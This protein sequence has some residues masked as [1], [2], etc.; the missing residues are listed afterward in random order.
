[1]SLSIGTRLGTVEVLGIIGRGGM[2]EVYRAR[3]TKL[4]RDVA[5]KTL[6]DEFSHDADRL[7]RFQREAEVL[8]SLNH[9]NIAAIY[10]LQ[11]AEGSR[12]L[13]LE[14]VEGETLANRIAG[15]PIPIDE[16]LPVAKSICEALEA[17]H[18]QGVVHR[19]LKPANVKI[20]P[21]GKVKV[22]D[23]GLA[24]AMEST[25][26]TLLSNSP[27]LISVA[28]SNAGVILGTAGY[29][30]PEQAKGQTVDRRTDIW[31]FGVVLYEMLTG[32][33]LFSGETVSETMAFVMTKE[34]DWKALPTETPW[35]L[36]KLLRRCLI[37]DPRSRLRDIGEARIA[38]AEV[39]SGSEPNAPAPQSVS[40]PSARAWMSVS[41]VLTLIAAGLALPAVRYFRESALP[42]PSEMRLEITTP[43]TSAPLEFA[44]SPDGRYTVFVASGDGPQRLWLRPL[45]KTQALPMTGTEGATSPFWSPNSRS[46]GFTAL[47]KLKRID[48]AGGPPQILAD[49]GGGRGGTWNSDG[50]ILFTPSAAAPLFRVF[51]SGGAP[52]AITKLDPVVSHRF[53]SFL[54]GG[55]QFLFY[56]QGPPDVAGIYLGSLDSNTVRRLTPADT[57]GAYASPGWLLWVRD[58]SLV[59]QHLDLKRNELT[60]DPVTLADTVAF[61][62]NASAG[63]LSVSAS[64]LLAYRRGETGRHQLTWF[65]RAGKSLG[66]FGTPDDST[67]S[68]LALSPDGR[69]VAVNRTVQ[70][71][72]DVW[73]LNGTRASRF[74][75]DAAVEEFA[76]WSPDG[77]RIA[78]DSIRKGVRDLYIKPSSGAE[79]EKLL[80]QTSQDKYVTDW[81]PD[82]RFLLYQSLDPQTS[83]DLWVLPL[84]GDQKP[85][86]FL[87]TRFA[88]VVG[89][90]SPDGRWVAYF[91]NESGQMEVYVRPFVTP[92]ANPAGNL[93]RG[94]WQVS[95][96]GG[97]YP[98]WRPDGKELYYTGLDGR[99]M[100]VPISATSTTLE[101]G[102]P[103]ELFKPRIYGRGNLFAGLGRQYDVTRD[104]RFLVNTV[105]DDIETA[106]ITLLQN[107]KPPNP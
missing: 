3:D 44:L 57:Y 66:T 61:D 32:R 51:A 62:A 96:A 89:L 30:S 56:A 78:F 72:T 9:P 79:D 101:P 104:G 68:F 2:G 92:G 60:G 59:A 71:N 36:E 73:L 33:M 54:P 103:V 29:M 86:P 16:A 4:K 90:F 17:A 83:Y 41:A 74:T 18:E 100:A 77:S 7:S 26:N 70:G 42:A 48:I 81:S 10:D 38:I 35:P 88:E 47:G 52:A 50:I 5:I 27:T 13:V 34:P 97:V 53:P 102:D 91:S 37:K 80:L 40:R 43:S 39:Q 31:A 1:V 12:F 24:K 69:R 93:A 20:T 98:R 28:A 99:I 63:A 49:S 15:G 65:D 106:P 82:G 21:D 105:L 19:D 25:P 94:Q 67:L 6:P 107:W 75:F 14:L 55:R 46:I 45:D 87:K 85:W 58:G 84:E 95:T 64:G 8:A 76:V 23:F 22:L 11:E